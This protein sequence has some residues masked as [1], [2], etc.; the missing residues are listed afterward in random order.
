VPEYPGP[1]GHVT[2]ERICKLY[3]NRLN[4]PLPEGA[5]WLDHIPCGL[6]FKLV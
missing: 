3:G 4:G 6:K 5:Q 2:G 1:I